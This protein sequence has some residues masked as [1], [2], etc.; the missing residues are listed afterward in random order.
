[1]TLKVENTDVI[2]GAGKGAD[3]CYSASYLETH[4]R[5]AEVWH[6]LSRNF[7]VLLAH[8]RVYPRTV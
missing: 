7:T 2:D 3:T 6:A 4:L 5:S 1:M 8:P